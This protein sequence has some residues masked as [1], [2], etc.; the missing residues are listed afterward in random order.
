MRK[1]DMEEK[2]VRQVFLEW[3]EAIKKRK[4][5]PCDLDLNDLPEGF[6]TRIKHNG[7][8]EPIIRVVQNADY[9]LTIYTT[10]SV[11]N[12]CSVIG[13]G[14][15]ETES[16]GSTNVTEILNPSEIFLNFTYTDST[17]E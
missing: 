5:E 16:G 14:T 17:D 10:E 4:T 11:F 8:L 12:S 6:P 9:T 13:Y 15:S 2:S 7:V 1:I 3:Q